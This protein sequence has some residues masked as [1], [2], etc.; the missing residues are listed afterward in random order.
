MR[1]SGVIVRNIVFTVSLLSLFCAWKNES[2]EIL[3]CIFIHSTDR[4]YAITMDGSGKVRSCHNFPSW[5]KATS[6]NVDESGNYCFYETSLNALDEPA[7][8]GT[9]VLQVRL[10]PNRLRVVDIT[11][12]HLFTTG[13]LGVT[14]K[15]NEN[16][17]T[18]SRFTSY[19][20]QLYAYKLDQS[21]K[22]FGREWPLFPRM[23]FGYFSSSDLN[24]SGISYDGTI[25]CWQSLGRIF[26]EELDIAGRP[27]GK[28]VLIDK[29]D[30]LYSWVNSISISDPLPSGRRLVAFSRV[31]GSRGSCYAFDTTVNIRVINSGT[32]S[33]VSERTVIKTSENDDCGSDDMV[34]ID[35][36]GSFIV[37]T[38]ESRK[39]LIYVRLNNLGMPTSK[40]VLASGVY[41]RF[42]FIQS[43][44]TF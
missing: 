40:R 10:E 32:L 7:A 4:S 14:Q 28:P 36:G 27:V 43:G 22:P 18:V 15:M 25:A 39:Q 21:G 5:L 12:L 16:L 19:K 33:P 24:G 3:S 30:N 26:L 1:R 31:D 34:A 20:G 41:P 13:A 9:N 23:F 6:G 17:L 44:S 37:Y 42:V 38:D 35:G 11:R 29:I 8:D 2:K